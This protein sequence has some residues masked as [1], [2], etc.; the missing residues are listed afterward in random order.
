MATLTYSPYSKWYNVK[1]LKKRKEK[2]EK[3]DEW[4]RKILS[5]IDINNFVKIIVQGGGIYPIRML[6]G[7]GVSIYSMIAFEISFNAHTYYI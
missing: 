1:C 3:N 4:K 7:S 2:K 6:G 5:R